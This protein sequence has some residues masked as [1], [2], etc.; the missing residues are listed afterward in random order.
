MTQADVDAGS[1]TNTATATGTPPT[2]PDVV[3]PPSTVRIPIT[4]AAKLGLV[5]TGRAVDLNGD[6][7]TNAGDRVDWTLKVTNLGTTTITDITVSDPSAGAVK[8][9]RTSL[10]PGASMTCTV[11]SHSVTAADAA[12][13]KV[14]NTATAGGTGSGGPVKSNKAVASV[15]VH[16]KVPVTVTPPPPG[17]LPFTGV[18]F[19][20][21]L[22]MGGVGLAVIG[23]LFVLTARRRDQ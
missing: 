12:R 1:I 6:R 16:R 18:A 2:G 10:A 9:P 19:G 7:I 22:I 5:K 21:Q 14:V 8:C 17:R 11:P 20:P 15:P 4:S 3:S 13:G 23:V